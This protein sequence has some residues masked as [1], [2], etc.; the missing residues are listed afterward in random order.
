VHPQSLTSAL[1]EDTRIL[2]D[3]PVDL[4]ASRGGG[5]GYG[6]LNSLYRGLGPHQSASEC[7]G[8]GK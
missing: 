6:T 5:G 4:C 7:Y 3:G 1:E 8:E 2:V